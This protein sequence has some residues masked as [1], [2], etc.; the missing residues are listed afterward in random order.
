MMNKKRSALVLAIT[1]GTVLTACGQNNNQNTSEVTSSSEMTTESEVEIESEESVDETDA[2]ENIELSDTDV[3]SMFYASAI[4]ETKTTCRLEACYDETT[5]TIVIPE[6]YN[7]MTVTE[8]GLY[9]VSNIQAKTVIVPDT[10]EIIPSYAFINCDNLENIQIGSGV[11]EVG[12]LAFCSCPEL[13]SV[14]FEDGLEKIA[15]SPFAACENLEQ[16]TIPASATDIEAPLIT[17]DQTPNVTVITPSGSVAEAQALEDGAK[18]ES[19]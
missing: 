16:L 9:G 4:D 2:S 17:L 12:S 18:V 11:K 3:N 15:S 6:E 19:Y 8:I 14:T 1:L 5:D 10:V 7:G 13:R